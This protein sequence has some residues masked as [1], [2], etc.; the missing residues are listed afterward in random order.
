MTGAVV[1]LGP[2]LVPAPQDGAGQRAAVPPAFCRLSFIP[3]R[4]IWEPRPSPR[5]PF[6]WRVTVLKHCQEQS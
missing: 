4:L 3:E 5:F 6:A 2:G 1:L